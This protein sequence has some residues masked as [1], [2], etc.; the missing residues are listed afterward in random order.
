[1]RSL[2]VLGVLCAVTGCKCGPSVAKVNPSLAVS[3]PGLDFGQVKV[4]DA[5]QRTVRLEAQTRSAVAISA[6]T[7]EGPGASSYRLG[8]LPTVVEAQGTATFTVTF[9]PSAV[10]AFTASLV[11]KSDDPE[12]PVTRLALAGEG[13]EP[14]LELTLDCV[15]TSGCTA[16]LV[17][18]PPSIDFGMEPLSRPVAPDPTK[19]PTLVVVNAGAVALQVSGVTFGGADAAAFSIAGSTFPDGGVRL[20][21]ASGFN[22][23]IRFVPTSEQQQAYSGEVVITSDDPARPA[24]TVQLRG[25]LKPNAPPVVC[26]NLVR[27]V[28]QTIGDAA[29]EYNTGAEWATLL[30]PPAG[31]YDFTGRR[32]VR[33]NE[34]AVFSATSSPELTSCSTDP[35]DGRTGLTY[36]WRL[37]SAPRGALGLAIGGATTAQAQLRPVAT[38][39]YTLELTVTDAHQG[40]TT[41]T[42][43]FSVA[44][45]QDFVA[46]LEWDGFAGVD[47]D[48][49]LVRPTAVTGGDAFTGAFS[50]FSAGPANKTSGDLNGYARRTRDMNA[51]AGYD[52][53][54]GDVGS[55]D[56]PT[57]NRDDV[58][59]GQ[60]LE[61][62][63]L[64][65]PE[66]DALCVTSAC[67]YRVLVHAFA[68]KRAP[69]AP[70]SCF[71]DGGVGCLDG[72]Q[73]ACATDFRCVAASAPAGVAPGG[74]GRCYEA[75]RPVVRLFFKGN[76]APA[77]VI[78]LQ[79]L[80]PADD[81]ALGAPCKLWHVADV[82]WPARSAIGS[83]PDGGT[84]PPVV[85]VIGADVSGRITSP[86]IKRFG[87][88][89]SGSLLCEPD[90]T[91]GNGLAWYSL[92]P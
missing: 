69:A 47:L 45:K 52:F 34:L 21:A 57:L 39:D 41:V 50:F 70:P 63:S 91:Q 73:C 84:P 46:Q 61:I 38:G 92:Q 90:S 2:F 29:R 72:T 87:T 49:H 40:A 64:N 79:N 11:I 27:V 4:G 66:N 71:V 88:R 1:M 19:L 76:P 81:V 77:N 67:T 17:A 30:V 23:P 65:Y 22:F 80:V 83:L 85:T 35:E 78:P 7:L 74:S 9:A 58:G 36:R 59:D 3:P 8:A 6:V 10:E 5:T 48:L 86:S 54:W 14:R 44:L 53:D 26:A 43:R 24:V 60:L 75:P 32:D 68:D 20:E 55:A 56:D 51:T 18:D 15:A 89:P 82:A 33:P 28:P 12:R 31:G 16:A 25:T 13:A 37:V 42:M 62:A